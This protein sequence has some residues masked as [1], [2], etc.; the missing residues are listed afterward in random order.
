M[1]FLNNSK[2]GSASYPD[3]QITALR[4][5]GKLEDAYELGIRTVADDPTKWNIGALGWVLIGLVKREAR[6]PQ[7]DSF[8]RFARELR[9]LDIPATDE[10][11]TEHRSQALALTSDEGRRFNDKRLAARDAYQAGHYEDAISH[12]LELAKNGH[13][14]DQDLFSFGWALSR[15]IQA[16]LNRA[17]EGNFSDVPVGR[18]KKFLHYYFKIGLSGPELLHSIILQQALALAKEGQ[19]EIIP[20]LQLWGVDSFRPEDWQRDVLE[21][22]DSGRGAQGKKRTLPA[23]GESV[24]LRAAKEAIRSQHQAGVDFVLPHLD[25]VADRFP[26]NA[27]LKRYQAELLHAIGRSD[28]ARD[29]AVAF[30]RSMSREYWAWEVLGDLVPDPDIKQGCYAKALICSPKEEFIGKL[31]LKFAECIRR[32]HPAQ[33]RG[34]IERVV[35]YKQQK[36]QR[37]PKKAEEL[38]ERSWFVD[39]QAVEPSASFYEQF[40]APADNYLVAQIPVRLAVIDRLNSDKKLFHFT[41]DKT[42]DGICLFSKYNDTPEVGDVVAVRVEQVVIAGTKKTNLLTIEPSD[43]PA[44]EHLLKKFSGPVRVSN[45]MGFMEDGTFISPALIG[46]SQISDGEQVKGRAIISYD[47]KRARWS[48]AALEVKVIPR[49]SFS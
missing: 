17:K 40:V 22:E 5:E 41:V 49:V 44:P 27:H 8:Q 7:S 10:L 30:V 47:K 35:R 6:N 20:F 36:G 15:A 46:A 45:G 2:R 13:L 48:F 28:E 29:R 3:K 14:Q 9:E 12:Y 24:F 32:D 16:I 1:T 38:S 25:K 39:A 33:A 37:I 34:E 18:A 26:D 43:Q 23:L 21:A 42:A 11:L 31:R 4:R 19:L